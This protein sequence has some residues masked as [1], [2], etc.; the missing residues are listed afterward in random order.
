MFV[1]AMYAVLALATG[2]LTYAN[3]GHNLPFLWRSGSERLERLA[4]GGIALGVLD[5][6]RFNEHVA[7]LERGDTVVFC[8][9]GI[10]EA[11]SLE[12]DMYGEDRLGALVRA[13]G[14]GSAQ[15]MLDAIDD[16]VTAFVGEAPHSDDRTLMVVR[17][18]K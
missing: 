15:T 18:L 3:A 10:T 14:G 6:I 8:T 12:R 17:R 16:S 4:K 5:G 11:F 7:T 1:T 13:T 2:E 9:D